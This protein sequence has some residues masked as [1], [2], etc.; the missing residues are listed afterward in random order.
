MSHTTKVSDI[1]FST[2]GDIDVIFM[3]GGYGT[4][5]DFHTNPPL[6]AAI[7]SMYNAN[8]T[9]VAVCHGPVCLVDCV[10]EDGTPLLE[11]KEVTVFS[12]AEEEM[13]GMVDKLPFLVESKFRELGAKYVKATD[14]WVSHVCADGNLI[15]G[16]NPASSIGCAKKV[17][18]MLA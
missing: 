17:I 6:K 10:K 13:A 5:I 3:C 11:G 2:E 12:D 8:K 7:E 4:C 15:T 1:D 14:P 9:V 16:Q 18:S